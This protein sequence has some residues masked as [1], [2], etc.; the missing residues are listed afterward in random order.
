VKE[1]KI[2][3]RQA[4]RVPITSHIGKATLCTQVLVPDLDYYDP[5]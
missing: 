4:A 1:L 5:E 3:V 2:G